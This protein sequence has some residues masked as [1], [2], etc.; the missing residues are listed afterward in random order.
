MWPIRAWQVS[1]INLFQQCQHWQDSWLCY[2]L[3]AERNK[4]KSYWISTCRHGTKREDS[5]L[6]IIFLDHD[7]KFKAFFKA[8][9]PRKRIYKFRDTLCTLK[10]S[11][12]IPR[13]QQFVYDGRYVDWSNEKLPNVFSCLWMK[14]NYW[15]DV[16]SRDWKLQIYGHG[17]SGWLLS[18]WYLFSV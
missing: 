16:L 12:R 18:E 15:T 9:S 7:L 10:S 14:C 8:S 4:D 2:F 1:G 11:S 6:R 13:G 17:D 5:F 3:L